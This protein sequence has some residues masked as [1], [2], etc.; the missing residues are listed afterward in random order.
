[1]VNEDLGVI[2]G[3]LPCDLLDPLG[4]AMM[5]FRARCTWNL[6]IGHIADED[7]PER[8]L[9]LAF[10]RRRPRRANEFFSHELT[11]AHLDEALLDPSDGS[12]R[13][14]PEDLPDDGSVL[15]KGLALGRK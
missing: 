5:L 8:Q 13:P 11:H 12:N 1:M 3:P 15:Q 14:A 6:L 7:M 9:V 10:D 4:C 2:A